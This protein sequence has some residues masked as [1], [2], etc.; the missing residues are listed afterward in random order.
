MEI[1][2]RLYLC[3]PA[4]SP[5]YPTLTPTTISIAWSL[6]LG[7][8]RSFLAD[9]QAYVSRLRP[10]L[11]QHGTPLCHSA[12]GCV[13]TANHYHSRT[14]RSWWIALALTAC[15]GEE[16]HW[17]MSDAWTYPDPLRSRLI[18]PLTRRVFRRLARIYGF[19]S[20]P[21]MPPRREEIER[22]ALAVRA[23]LAYVRHAHRPLLGLIPEG[24]DSPDGSLMRPPSGVGRFLLLLVRAGLAI[25]PAGIYEQGGVVHLQWGAPIES[26]PA[27]GSIDERD[28]CA[29]DT[30]M[31]AIAACLPSFLRGAYA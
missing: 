28:R 15:L 19:T 24:S 18:T 17:V 16:I 25:Q 8:R 10:P 21:P 20:M 22:R 11:E 30:I 13:V 23:V 31:K 7:R 3:V 27:S 2:E 4:M 29:A 12:Q 6:V 14:F 26:L 1:R 9:A 5:S